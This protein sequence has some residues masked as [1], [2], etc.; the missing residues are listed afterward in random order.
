M[1]HTVTEIV[2]VSS[3]RF[4]NLRQ[5]DSA[6]KCLIFF[7]ANITT[8]KCN[9][10]RSLDLQLLRHFILSPFTRGFAPGPHVPSWLHK[11]YIT[12]CARVN[13]KFYEGPNLHSDRPNNIIGCFFVPSPNLLKISRTFIHNYFW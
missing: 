10:A 11:V 8:K 12:S 5:Q 6:T 9:F 4:K 3:T 2:H 7:E 1:Y 13:F